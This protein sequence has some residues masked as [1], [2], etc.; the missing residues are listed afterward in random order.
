[1]SDLDA[2]LAHLGRLKEAASGYRIAQLLGV[3]QSTVSRWMS[4]ARL[5]PR[6]AQ[7]LRWFRRTCEESDAGNP[8]AVRMRKA[9]LD[10]D[11]VL[12][13]GERGLLVA[14]GL[15]WLFEGDA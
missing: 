10:H 13:M 7:A 9:F 12:G 8:Q 15:G 6:H 3:N 2:V 14:A 4:G 5:R 11:G 1:M